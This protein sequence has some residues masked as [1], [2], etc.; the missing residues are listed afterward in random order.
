MCGGE[1]RVQGRGGEDV[2]SKVRRDVEKSKS[3]GIIK[4]SWGERKKKFNAQ[5]NTKL[6]GQG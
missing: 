4:F 1:K 6:G 3:R 5:S 2:S